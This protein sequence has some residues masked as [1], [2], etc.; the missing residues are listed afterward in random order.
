MGK[1]EAGTRDTWKVF[2][3]FAFGFVLAVFVLII[4]TSAWKRD[5]R[6]LAKGSG[7]PGRT[8]CQCDCSY[9]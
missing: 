5:H 4:L 7:S 9:L 2:V 6:C 8:P 1:F 3:R